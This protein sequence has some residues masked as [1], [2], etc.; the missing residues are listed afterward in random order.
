MS[1]ENIELVRAVA[2]VMWVLDCED[3]PEDNA[4]RKEAF[5][6]AK[7]DVTKKARK[8]VRQLERRGVSMTYDASAAKKAS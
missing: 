3:L 4:A 2:R 7:P 1:E 8:L 5:K 6:A